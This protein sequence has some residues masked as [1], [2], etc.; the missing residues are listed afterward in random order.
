MIAHLELLRPLFQRRI[1]DMLLVTTEAG[2]AVVDPDD[3]E[4]IDGDEGPIYSFGPL[5]TLMENEI[6]LS[7]FDE[8]SCESRLITKQGTVSFIPL[9][10]GAVILR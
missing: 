7:Q 8:T 5:G 3:I 10:P 4:V 2:S 1:C 6:L 9:L